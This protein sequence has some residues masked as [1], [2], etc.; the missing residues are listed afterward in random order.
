MSSVGKVEEGSKK[1]SPFAKVPLIW[2]VV[3]G[4]C[5]GFLVS[6]INT[7]VDRSVIESAN[8][9]TPLWR[10]VANGFRSLVFSP[11]IFLRSYEFRWIFFVYSSTYAS[12]NLA[13]HVIVNGIDPA[14]VKLVISFVVNTSTSLIKDKAL[15]QAFGNTDARPFPMTSFGLFLLRDVVAMAS[16]FTIPPIL[17]KYIS[18]KFGLEEKTGL[19]IGQ[20]TS[21]LLV[22]FVGTPLHLLGL[23]FYNNVGHT[24]SQRM[25]TLRSIYFSTLLLRMMRFL[26]A[27][28]FGGIA[29]I[30]L[31]NYFLKKHGQH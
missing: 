9:K 7:I 5:S 10:G 19:R 20:L 25:K 17:G 8:G 21:P 30:E 18:D 11:Q 22:Q 23:D 14:I 13:D 15:A 26:P 4:I 29:N 28:G 31:R 16:A 24:F 6:P 3:A 2:E 12:S 1:I 27:Y